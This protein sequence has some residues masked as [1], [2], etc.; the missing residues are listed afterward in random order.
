MLLLGS[1]L[2]TLDPCKGKSLR[3]RIY[4][5]GALRAWKIKQGGPGSV[6][7]GYGLGMERLERFRFSVPAV[8]LQKGFVCVSVH[9]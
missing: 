3:L 6:R 8:P 9:F 5:F 7:F 2:A 4:D 1:F